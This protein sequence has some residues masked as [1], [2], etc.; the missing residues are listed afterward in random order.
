MKCKTSGHRTFTFRWIGEVRGTGAF[1]AVELV[2]DQQTREPLAPYGGSSPEMAALVAAC[3]AR[4]LLP[5]ANVNRIHLVPPL[6]VSEDEVREAVRIL[7][8]AL[9][10]GEAAASA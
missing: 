3:K 5:F 8:E 9:T 10:E 2:R 7:D 4:G 6:N 1:W